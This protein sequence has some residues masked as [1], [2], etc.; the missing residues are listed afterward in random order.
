MEFRMIDVITDRKTMVSFRKDS[1]VVSFGSE[2][3]FGDEDDYMKRIEDRMIRFPEGIVLVEHDGIPI[4]QIE[5]QIVHYQG[6]DIGYVNLFYLTPE[7]RSKGFGKQLVAYAESFFNRQQVNEYHLRV[8]PTNFHAVRFYEK[9][10]LK[11]L[12]KEQN[13]Y[14]VWRMIKEL[15]PK[16]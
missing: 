16:L 2:E 3:G 6:K 11:I 14:E 7:N 10:G 5:L 13:K 15:N 9:H 1:Y 8:S 12:E 4:G